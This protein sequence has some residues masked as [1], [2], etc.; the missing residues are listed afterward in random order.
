VLELVRSARSKVFVTSRVLGDDELAEA[1]AATA[2][3]LTG[4]VYVI[5]ELDRHGPVTG[6]AR[7]ANG[8]DSANSSDGEV[9][10]RVEV[11][12]RRLVALAGRGVR[13]R[14]HRDCHA[15]FVV[16][17]DAVAWVGTANLASEAF[18]HVGEVGV[19]TTDDTEVG[20]LAR[21]FARM[22]LAGCDR[23]LPGARGGGFAEPREPAP[24]SFRVPVAAEAQAP[25]VVWSD[26]ETGGVLGSIHDV[27]GRAERRLLLASFSLNG[28]LGRPDL[29]INPLLDAIGRGVEVEMLVRAM[30]ERDRHRRDAGLLTDLGVR[31]V[32]DEAN[33]AK[34]AVADD[35]H[36]VLFTPD[37]DAEGGLDAG[38]GLELAARLDGTPALPALAR[39]L[40]HALDNATRHY[41]P[42]PTS[43]QLHDDLGTRWQ[44][45]W[46]LSF[47]IAVAAEARVWRQL[48]AEAR[49][50]VLWTRQPGQHVELLAGDSRLRLRPSG[51]AVYHLEELPA[52][53]TPARERLA[54]WWRTPPDGECGY[55][56]A[57][58][59]G[60]VG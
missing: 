11:A 58:L 50:P 51:G 19:V 20:R 2:G 32:A 44:H 14:G 22:W 33:H 35:R 45:R 16:V 27:I 15:R 28:M 8:A 37:F 26:G 24:V 17:D 59:V 47:E 39:Y 54:R 36:G 12:G 48:R 3:R 21:L 52:P 43:R 53:E 42:K 29:L 4:G 5:T 55:C 46:P 10:P 13:V 57:V 56:P 40:R 41:L 34:A 18:D 23:E 31:I 1:L 60:A 38:N 9:E 7:P 49:E 6:M 25:A 30:N